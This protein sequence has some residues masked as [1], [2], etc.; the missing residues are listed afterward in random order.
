MITLYCA[1]N[2][3]P[4]LN[5]EWVRDLRGLWAAEECGVPYEIH[6]LDTSKGEQREAAYKTV[7]PF[8]IIPALTDGDFKLF[9]SGAVVSYICDAAGQHIPKPG[10]ALRPVVFCGAEHGRAASLSVADCGRTEQGRGMGEGA[11]AT[12]ARRCVDPVVGTRCRAFGPPVLARR[13][14]LGRRHS[15][16]ACVELHHRSNLARQHSARESVP[17]PSARAAGLCSRPRCTGRRRELRGRRR[18]TA[19]RFRTLDWWRRRRA[20]TCRCRLRQCVVA[21]MPQ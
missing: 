18:I 12:V 1:G 4:F 2:R 14:V 21:G 7:N 11:R 13:R 17:C 5:P 20:V 3:P 9:E 15:D 8:G 10:S 16:G 19:E 6:W